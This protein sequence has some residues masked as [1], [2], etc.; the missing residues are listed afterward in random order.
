MSSLRRRLGI[1]SSSSSTEPSREPSPKPDEEF[2]VVSRKKLDKI[3]KSLSERPKASKRRNAWVF[4]LGGLFGILL[5][6]IFAKQNDLM[7]LAALQDLNL[8]S[9]RDVLPTGF[10]NDARDFQVDGPLL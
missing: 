6:G 7:D 5:A 9:F 8:E 4:G 1:G 3:N 10:M 2:R